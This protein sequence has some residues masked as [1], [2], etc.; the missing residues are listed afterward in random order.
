MVCGIYTSYRVINYLK[1]KDIPTIEV[2][3]VP[4]K[5]SSQVLMIRG[6]TVPRNQRE[7]LI[8]SVKKT[9][10][11]SSGQVLNKRVSNHVVRSA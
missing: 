4:G 8:S 1:I 5:S 7:T 3:E 6:L 10:F 11:S 9:F 2:S